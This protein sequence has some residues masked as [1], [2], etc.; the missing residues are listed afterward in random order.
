MRH[1]RFGGEFSFSRMSWV[2]PNF[3]WMMFRSGWAMKVGQEVV[4]A[5]GVA[6]A[7]FDRL[8][9]EAVPSTFDAAAFASRDA[10]Q[11]AV[12]R[13]DVRVQWDPD[14]DPLGRPVARRAL[15][16]GLRGDALARYAR[17]WIAFIEDVTPFVRE[18]HPNAVEPFDRLVTPREDVYPVRDAAVE[19]RR[20]T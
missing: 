8:L 20:V 3:L 4:L 18:Q 10:W 13:S 17:E 11:A 7:G 12:E 14:H 16:L 19:A 15:Q 9:E 6:R 5:I 1:Q 2:K